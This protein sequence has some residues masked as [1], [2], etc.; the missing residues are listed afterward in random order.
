VTRNAGLALGFTLAA[1]AVGG[2]RVLL[3]GSGDTSKQVEDDLGALLDTTANARL[4]A[5]EATVEGQRSSTGSYAGAPVTPPIVLARADA[6]SYCIELGQG[7]LARH[8]AGPNGS[9]ASGPC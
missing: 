8:V 9:P 6:T 3:P 7:K 5:A 1:V 2:W 4:T